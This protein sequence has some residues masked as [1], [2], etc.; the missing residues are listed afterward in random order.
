MVAACAIDDIRGPDCPASSGGKKNLTQA[1][2]FRLLRCFEK[3][4][5][6]ASA[7]EGAS[8]VQP[9]TTANSIALARIET[10]SVA[11]SREHTET[12]LNY[13]LSR[14]Q[15]EPFAGVRVACNPIEIVSG[16]TGTVTMGGGE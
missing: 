9:T 12:S 7:A 8:A 5:I 15:V 14:V 10:L 11:R 4:N 13:P 1:C 16:L 6:C 3:S 2:S